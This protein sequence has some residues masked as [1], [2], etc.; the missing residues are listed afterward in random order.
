M[1]VTKVRKSLL[2]VLMALAIMAGL[3]TGFAHTNAATLPHTSGI[4]AS[5]VQLAD[6]CPAPPRICSPVR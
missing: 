5:H 1:V 6:W 3:I 4:N 2:T